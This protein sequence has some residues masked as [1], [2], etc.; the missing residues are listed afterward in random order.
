MKEIDY[1]ASEEVVADRI[2]TKTGY[3]GVRS[4]NK[5][6]RIDRIFSDADGTIRSLVEIKTRPDLALSDFIRIQTV[7]VDEQKI[8]DGIVLSEMIGAPFFVFIRTLKD[9]AVFWIKICDEKARRLVQYEVREV[10]AQKNCHSDEK[11]KKERAF[12]P[13]G[14]FTVF[15]YDG[16][17]PGLWE[18]LENNAAQ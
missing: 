16:R 5:H 17:Q 1:I 14:E 18:T 8:E 13:I 2:A 10:L 9:D 7:W 3:V 15:N 6:A 12:I 11:V 4:R